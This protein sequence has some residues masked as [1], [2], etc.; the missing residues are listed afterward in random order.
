MP[1]EFRILGPLEISADARFVPLGSPKQ[2]ALLGL[3]LLHADETLSR[4]RLIEELWGEAPPATVDSALHV[5][6]SRLRRLLESAGAGGALVRERYGYRLRVKAEQL[7]ANR[8]EHLA[9][10][11][12]EALAAGKSALAADRLR[13]ALALWR[14]PALADLQSERFAITAAARLEE[15]RVAALEQRLEADLALDRHRQL[16]HELKVL[17]AEHPYRERL[18]AQLML[19]LYR[20]GRQ[21]EALHAYQQARRTLA[22]DLGLEPSQELRQLEQAILR[23]DATLTREPPAGLNAEPGLLVAPAPPRHPAMRR[24]AVRYARSSDVNIAYQVVGEGPRDLVLVSGFVSH[25]QLDWE[26]PRMAHYLERLASF[27][28]LIRFDKRGTGL[29]DRPGGLPDLE[30]RMDDVRAVM[31]A[32]GS[33]RAAL[34]GT[35]EGGPM[36]V[37]FAATHPARTTALVLHGAY[38]KRRDPDDDYPWAPTWDERQEH[39]GEIERS[40]GYEADIKRM[41]PS[42][43]EAMAEWWARR[44]QAAASP[45]AARDLILMNSQVDIRHVLPTV[46]VPTLVLHRTG[47]ID[48]RVEEGRYIAERIPGA[49]FVELAGDDHVPWVDADQI[50]DEVEEFLTGTR[51]PPRADSVLTTLLV[52]EIAASA[53]RERE[54]GERHWRQLIDSLHAGVRRELDQFRGREIDTPR[55]GLLATFDGPARAVRA[56]C[57]IRDG[58]RALGLEIRAGIHTGECELVDGAVRG[59][60]VDAVA[61]VVAQAAPGQVLASSTVHDLIAGSGIEF[62]EAGCAELKGIGVW[63]LYEAIAA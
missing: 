63:Q 25:L 31:D 13:Q 52:T 12:S 19:A 60:A 42:A 48:S 35:S 57:A 2:T 9:G 40:W 29:S 15:E 6:L 45:G 27:S 30:T 8:F 54:L 53:Q 16:I 55:D 23:H 44:A 58:V 33:K 4:D 37:L 39:A 1:I 36:S 61:R 3:L 10:E 38:A 32:A 47:D 34:L 24:P 26:E 50:V 7:D 41:M 43:D 20:S 46:T 49:R 28:R 5:Y 11:G 18:R 21:A 62:V 17:V 14:G 51:P 22:D 56:A 59:I